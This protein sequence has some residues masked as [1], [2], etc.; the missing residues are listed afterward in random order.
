M[1]KTNYKKK[2]KLANTK[3]LKLIKPNQLENLHKQID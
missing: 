3:N 2:L 1:L